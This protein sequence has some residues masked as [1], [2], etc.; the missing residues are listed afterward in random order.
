MQLSDKQ[1]LY[2]IK[3]LKTRFDGDVIIDMRTK[4]F[5]HNHNYVTYHL[6]NAMTIYDLASYYPYF[7]KLVMIDKQTI[8]TYKRGKLVNTFI[9]DGSGD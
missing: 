8:T 4:V 3:Y 5:M 9:I 1:I 7:D 2:L 6:N